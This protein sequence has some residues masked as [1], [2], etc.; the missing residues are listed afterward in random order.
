MR[1]KNGADCTDWFPELKQGLR[2]LA[3]GCVLDGEICVLDS[4]GRADFE[5]LHARA[6]RKRWYKGAD[7]VV[8]CAF[9]LL[10]IKGSDIRQTPIEERKQRLES[11]LSV[12]G[13]SLSMLYVQAI[14]DQGE[15]LYRQC[16]ALG[17][18]GVV[19]KRAGSTYQS[20]VRSPDWIKVKVP[21]VHEHG[22]FKRGVAPTLL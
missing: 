22:A 21:G 10:V 13:E 15:W 4:L 12:S 17:L 2:A 3:G 1:T 19:C 18:E 20:G 9:D 8:F 6:Q 11:L 16:I 5:R 14:P 7:P